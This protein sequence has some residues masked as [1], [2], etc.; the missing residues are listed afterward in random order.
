[1]EFR[2]GKCLK[3]KKDSLRGFDYKVGKATR[4]ACK[5]CQAKA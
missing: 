1:M 2:C 5:G 3:M 4:T